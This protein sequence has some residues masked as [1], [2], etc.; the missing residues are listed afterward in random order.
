MQNVPRGTLLYSSLILQCV[1]LLITFS[2]SAWAAMIIVL[3]YALVRNVPR[4]TK[5]YSY[6]FSK[7]II[8]LLLIVIMALFS[9]NYNLKENLDKSVDDRLGYIN[10]SRGTIKN[11]LWLGIGLGQSV[12]DLVGNN[13][14]KNWQFQPVH[15]VFLLIIQ[16]L[17]LIGTMILAC[18]ILLM[19]HVEHFKK[20]ETFIYFKALI[21]SFVFVMFFDHYFWD[22]QQGQ[23][24]LV[25]V[26]ALSRRA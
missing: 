19:F 24:M 12:V 22:I 20:T 26:L 11:N 16:E 9:L 5:I 6:L 21:I 10:V 1:G 2:K 18:L 7:K 8:L 4:G 25:I 23:L 3:S 14:L 15:N 13:D 17:G